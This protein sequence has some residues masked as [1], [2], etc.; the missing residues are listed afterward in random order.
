MAAR[1]ITARAATSTEPTNPTKKRCETDG[2]I[3][4]LLKGSILLRHAECEHGPRR[5]ALTRTQ[6][7]RGKVR[8]IRRVGKMLRLEAERR[9]ASVDV[10]AL[11]DRAAVEIVAGVQLE[12]RLR[13][14]H[15][16]GAA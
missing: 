11:A 9:P 3:A 2:L 10:A 6:D 15:V 4:C 12:S 5:K 1:T 8:M 14:G 7:R 13:G 16:E